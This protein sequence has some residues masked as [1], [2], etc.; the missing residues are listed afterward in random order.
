MHIS[1]DSRPSKDAVVGM[2]IPEEYTII[3]GESNENKILVAANLHVLF[4]FCCRV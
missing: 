4:E 3:E 1:D 2:S